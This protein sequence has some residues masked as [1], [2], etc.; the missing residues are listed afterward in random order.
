M[1]ISRREFL[2]GT[3]ALIVSFSAEQLRAIGI[4]AGS[5]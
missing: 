3:G 2:K 4:R 1:S 5:V